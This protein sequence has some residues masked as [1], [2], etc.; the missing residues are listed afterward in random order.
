MTKASTGKKWTRKHDRGNAR[1]NTGAVC[2]CS[3]RY[4]IANETYYN[5]KPEEEEKEKEGRERGGWPRALGITML[6][7]EGMWLVSP[8]PKSCYH[9]Q[10]NSS[11][12]SKTVSLQNVSDRVGAGAMLTIYLLPLRLS[13]KVKH[14]IIIYNQVYCVM[15]CSTK[16]SLSMWS[17]R[18]QM[19]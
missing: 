4:A 1:N 10:S 3:K 11:F 13:P 15:L 6:K 12:R 17:C 9:S 14:S 19:F 16:C 18:F 5:L 8:K 7:I 2:A